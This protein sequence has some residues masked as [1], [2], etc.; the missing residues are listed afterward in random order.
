MR[1][2]TRTYTVVFAAFIILLALGSGESVTAAPVT[3]TR[4]SVASDGSQGDGDSGSTADPRGIPALS[5][6]GRY[7]AF[8]SEATNLVPNDTNNADDVFVHDLLTRQTTRVSVATGGT[9]G[10]GYSCFPFM[11]ADGRFVVFVSSASNLTEGDISFYGDIFIHDRSAGQTSLISKT[12]YGCRGNNSSTS[13]SISADGRYV[14][15]QSDANNLIGT[16]ICPNPSD[17]CH[18]VCVEDC[19]DTSN[20]SDIFIHDRLT[21]K[22]KMITS[23]YGEVGQPVI[24]GNGRYVA[25]L[26][27]ESLAWE[28]TNNYPDVYVYDQ[29]TENVRLGS[30]SWYGSATNLN[31]KDPSLSYDGRY[32][33]FTSAASNLIPGGDTNS[34]F[35]VFVR[36]FQAGNTARVSIASDGEEGYT[37][38]WQPAISADGRFVTFISRAENL[39]PGDNNNRDDIF[40]HDRDADMDAIFDEPGAVSTTRLSVSADNIEADNDSDEPFISGDG[41]YVAFQSYASSLVANDTNDKSDIFLAPNKFSGLSLSSSP[42]NDVSP[43][44]VVTFALQLSWMSGDGQNVSGA[45]SN[46][47]PALT[48]YLEG[49]A[50]AGNLYYDRELHTL[51]WDGI[52]VDGQTATIVYT[53]QV[54]GCRDI[55]TAG[56]WPG[57]LRNAATAGLGEYRF[58]ARKMLNLLPPDLIVTGIEVTQGIQNLNN[59]VTLIAGKPDTLARV[60][61]Q[62]L[63]PPGIQECDVLN[64]TADLKNGS[65]SSLTPLNRPVTAFSQPQERPSLDERQGGGVLNFRLPAGWIDTAGNQVLTAKVD[66]RNSIPESDDGNNEFTTTVTFAA[67]PPLELYLYRVLWIQSP[68]GKLHAAR[69]GTGQKIVSALKAML[70]F[71]TVEVRYRQY[72]FPFATIA[73][74]GLVTYTRIAHALGTKLAF[75]KLFGNAPD[76]AIAY[77]YL[78]TFDSSLEWP[79]EGVTYPVGHAA[80]GGAAVIDGIFVAV[81][82]LGHIFGLAHV[83]GKP[84]D[85][86]KEP[87]QS[88]GWP[89]IDR[90][91][92]HP[93]GR[94]STSQD[95]YVGATYFG[96]SSLVMRGLPSDRYDIMTYC[97]GDVRWV[98]NY[99]WDKV[100]QAHPV[101]ESANQTRLV[102]PDGEYLMV[103]GIIST[104]ANTA[105]LSTFCRLPDLPPQPVPAPGDYAIHLL[106]DST[107]LASYPFTAPV[108][109]EG[110]GYAAFLEI[111]PYITG[112]E[113]IEIVHDTDVLAERLVSLHPPTVTLTLPETS[114][115]LTGTVIITF[116][117]NDADE[118][119]LSFALFYSPDDGQTWLNVELDII[120]ATYALDTFYLPGSDQARL[121][122]IVSDGVNTGQ[123]ISEAFRVA[124]KGPQ[125]FILTPEDQVF[126]PWNEPIRLEGTAWDEEDGLITGASLTWTDSIS[127]SLGTGDVHYVAGLT[128]GW[129]TITLTAT[130]S[131]NS[132]HTAVVRIHVGNQV[133]LPLAVKK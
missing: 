121:R 74:P 52:L 123:A 60:F 114:D 53:V 39:A 10:N 24:S 13:P 55:Y 82:E 124:R 1:A 132:V 122:V 54:H 76:S 5:A 4:V 3:I 16:Y 104:T 2:H 85:N 56:P 111:V 49:S 88:W 27:E 65:G 130:D 105:E 79:D 73:P 117:A 66:A 129:H 102:S 8:C 25:F 90:S 20:T 83:D 44:Q 47:L 23:W 31:S 112:T 116:T 58:S 99:Y 87:Y 48:T 14:A 91:Y 32:L 21:G 64:V 78:G 18:C 38:S 107:L 89:W 37:S 9:Q 108:D 46:T 96:F 133:W 45:I 77:G 50:D 6:D 97:T 17:P 29:Q 15:F 26:T 70:P 127:G 128:V 118:D 35:D 12:P 36:D 103:S 84:D 113:R 19:S 119:A 92:P 86:C 81:H 22:T 100:R 42:I 120:T 57:Q 51:D 68:L 80:A 125:A 34:N 30:I 98:S 67:E 93:E 72:F 126:Y 43:G 40:V 115:P 7:V 41:R 61:V 131:D 75:E 94:L 28:D 69:P 33:A 101:D 110:L 71:P 106:D 59:D 62:S 109:T 95:P 11:S 63:P